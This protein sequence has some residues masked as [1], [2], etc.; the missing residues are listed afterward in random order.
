MKFYLYKKGEGGG[1]LASLKRRGGGGTT[2]FGVVLTRGLEVLTILERG[3]GEGVGHKRF[4]SLKKK[5]GGGR[6][7]FQSCN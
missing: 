3:G 5:K 4:P 1:V 7:K 6:D 2:S